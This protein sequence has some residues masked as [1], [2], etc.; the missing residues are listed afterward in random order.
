LGEV[1]DLGEA[2][3]ETRTAILFNMKQLDHQIT[4]TQVTKF[5]KWLQQLGVNN[6]DDIEE[7]PLDEEEDAAGGCIEK[8]DRLD[9]SSD[10]DNITNEDLFDEEV[11]DEGN[12]FN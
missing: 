11:V 2:K 8:F 9:I 5:C 4:T 6:E 1:Q 12:I 3:I 10:I 7:E